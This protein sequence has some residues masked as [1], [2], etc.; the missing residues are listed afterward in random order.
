MK[1]ELSLKERL[2]RYLLK[3]HGF[4][5]SGDLQRIVAERTTYSPQN[6]GRRLRELVESGEL[7]VSYRKGHAWYQAKTREDPKTEA[8][9]KVAFFNAYQS[10]SLKT[11]L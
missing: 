8:A 5:A 4:V 10:Q 9:R 6:V 3:Q 2:Y 11:S 7:E 1:S